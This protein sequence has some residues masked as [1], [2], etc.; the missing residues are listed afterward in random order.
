M[1]K[2]GGV[3]S[4]RKVKKTAKSKTLKPIAFKQTTKKKNIY[5]NLLNSNI[6]LSAIKSLSEKEST[7][8]EQYPLKLSKKFY[9]IFNSIHETEVILLKKYSNYIEKNKDTD[10]LREKAG[11]YYVIKDNIEN[12]LKNLEKKTGP[13]LESQKKDIPNIYAKLEKSKNKNN[14]DKSLITEYR[15]LLEESRN[16]YKNSDEIVER[17]E[18]MVFIIVLVDEL[19]NAFFKKETNNSMNDLTS[20]MKNVKVKESELDK[21][22]NVFQSLK[23]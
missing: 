22:M 15:N 1:I 3:R 11:K 7:N 20:M 13:F 10:K 6:K 14:Y 17:D 5:K 4:T 19:L 2:S 16:I 12:K 18:A 9:N 23:L 8:I 21:I